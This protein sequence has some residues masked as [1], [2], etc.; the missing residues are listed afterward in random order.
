MFQIHNYYFLLIMSH[1]CW[2]QEDWVLCRVF[3]K[4]K[5]DINS[6]NKLSPQLMFEAT[7]PSSPPTNYQITMPVIGCNNQLA[8]FPSSMATTTTTQNYNNSFL[9]LLQFSLETNTNCSSITQISTPKC[10]DD[11]YGFLWDMDLEENSF[12]D[13]T[14]VT[15]NLDGIRF[16]VGNNNSMVL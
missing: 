5:S 13:G 2:L 6:A 14:T 12:Q 11:G 8:P 9:N 10:D 4:G 15:S 7:P 1:L 16:E 3:H